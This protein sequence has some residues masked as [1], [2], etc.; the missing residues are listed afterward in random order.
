MI[1]EHIGRK[2]QQAREEAGLTQ[3]ELAS[4]LGITQ[5]A[6]SNYELGKRRLHLANLNR[7]AKE[8]SRPIAFFID[9]PEP[10]PDPHEEALLDESI[11][12]MIS[13]WYEMPE[14]ERQYLLDYIRWRRGRMR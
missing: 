7:I 6:L 12:E 3:D 2:I 8:L 13:L 4:R 14:D 5:A 1:N 11:S 10:A 9:E